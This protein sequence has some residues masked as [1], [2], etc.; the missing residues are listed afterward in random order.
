MSDLCDEELHLA[1]IRKRERY[2]IENS[3]EHNPKETFES[4]SPYETRE[5]EEI[6]NASYD[7]RDAEIFEEETV[8]EHRAIVLGETVGSVPDR[9]P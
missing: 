6:R 7:R 5:D 4:A 8:V 2:Y 3:C 9:Y 1:D